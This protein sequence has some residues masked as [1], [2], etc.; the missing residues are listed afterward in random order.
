MGTIAQTP[1]HPYKGRIRGA[2]SLPASWGPTA[3]VDTLMIA[4][5]RDIDGPKPSKSK[6]KRTDLLSPNKS[7]VYRP[8]LTEPGEVTLACNMRADQIQ[9]AYALFD[10]MAFFQVIFADQSTTSN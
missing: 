5:V 1:T 8:G 10:T 2:T 4:G 9:A 3:G 6:S 7:H